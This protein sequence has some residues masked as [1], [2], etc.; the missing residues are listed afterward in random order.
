M[1]S[2]TT[3]LVLDSLIALPLLICVIYLWRAQ[4]DKTALA[5]KIKAIGSKKGNS[6]Y[7]KLYSL[8]FVKVVALL[9]ISS[10]A[11]AIEDIVGVA[12]GYVPPLLRLA[13]ALISTLALIWA[14]YLAYSLFRRK[15]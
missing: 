8:D 5:A 6:N 2:F 11:S 9:T 1:S 15:I 14:V 3:K 7:K 4:S 10:L 13:V 12:L